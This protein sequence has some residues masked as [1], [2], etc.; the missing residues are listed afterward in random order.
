MEACIMATKALKNIDRSGRDTT[1]HKSDTNGEADFFF[2]IFTTRSFDVVRKVKHI[3]K[4]V[5]PDDPGDASEEEAAGELR[6]P[7][8]R[9]ELVGLLL[10][11]GEGQAGGRRRLALAERCDSVHGQA[12]AEDDDEA[13]GGQGAGEAVVLGVPEWARN[14]EWAYEE[15]AMG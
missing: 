4:E 13:G 8:R 15:V 14:H 11:A 1:I 3:E 2:I 5:S 6:P 10:P 7:V 12:D 9:L